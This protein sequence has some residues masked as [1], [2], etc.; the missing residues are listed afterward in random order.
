METLAAPAQFEQNIRKSRFLA[1]AAPCADPEAA[2]AFIEQASDPACRHNSWAFRVGDVYRFDD[3]GEPGGTAGQPILQAIEHQRLDR[4]AVVVSRWFGGIKLGTG[5]LIRAY[6]GTAAECLRQARRRPIVA[7]VRLD[8]EL[9]FALADSL[10]H[11]MDRHQAMKLQEEYASGGIR[12][13]IK[14]P[15]DNRQAFEGQ[16]LE[17][18]RG[19]CRI[20]AAGA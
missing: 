13:R 2:A 6:G 20:K 17:A 12:M 15:R 9:P 11:L 7:M 1:Q 18:S 3:A 14:L 10:H 16:L 8:L 19:Q 5:G 4:V